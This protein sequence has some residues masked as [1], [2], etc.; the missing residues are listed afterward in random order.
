MNQI[1]LTDLKKLSKEEI[2]AKIP[3]AVTFNMETIAKL[4]PK[5]WRDPRFL[6][7]PEQNYE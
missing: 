4:V 7:K 6:V 2:Q 1:T 3:V 5:T